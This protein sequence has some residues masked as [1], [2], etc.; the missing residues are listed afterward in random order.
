MRTHGNPDSVLKVINEYNESIVKGFGTMG[1]ISNIVNNM[2]K[3]AELKVKFITE[4]PTLDKNVI[5]EAVKNCSME[6]IRKTL[7]KLINREKFNSSAAFIPQPYNLARVLNKEGFI[8]DDVSWE[9]H[10]KTMTGDKIAKMPLA[11]TGISLFMIWDRELTDFEK[12]IVQSAL[13]KYSE[14]GTHIVDN[15]TIPKPSMNNNMFTVDVSKIGKYYDVNSILLAVNLQNRVKYLPEN[16]TFHEKQTNKYNTRNGNW[17]S[18]IVKPTI[19]MSKRTGKK[20]LA[21]LS[22]KG[23]IILSKYEE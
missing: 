8:N 2:S 19:V 3:Q 11:D 5:T 16:I 12:D 23:E 14:T 7:N 22:D 13:I 21:T 4:F 10:I 1:N 20:W 15:I 17:E 9:V 18:R 6:S